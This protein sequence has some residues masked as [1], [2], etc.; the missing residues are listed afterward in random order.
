MQK[1]GRTEESALKDSAVGLLSGASGCKT[2]RI[3]IMVREMSRDE[4]QTR[5]ACIPRH[6]NGISLGISYDATLNSTR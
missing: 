5:I 3:G 1:D 4:F 2:E 6:A